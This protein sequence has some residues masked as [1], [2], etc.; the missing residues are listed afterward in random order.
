M[1]ED[2][3]QYIKGALYNINGETEPYV[4]TSISNGAKNCIM[5]KKSKLYD[6]TATNYTRDELTLSIE[7]L[8]GFATPVELTKAE[9]WLAST[10][11]IVEKGFINPGYYYII[12]C[13]DKNKILKFYFDRRTQNRTAFKTTGGATGYSNPILSPIL[14]PTL[15]IEGCIGKYINE[16]T[17]CDL[18][19]IYV[20][21]SVINSLYTADNNNQ[22]NGILPSFYE[23]K[24]ESSATNEAKPQPQQSKSFLSFFSFG[25]PTDKPTDNL[26]EDPNA[27]PKDFLCKYSDPTRKEIYF[28][29]ISTINE[30]ENAYE[31][32]ESSRQKQ[33]KL[34]EMS[35]NARSKQERTWG[36]WISENFGNNLKAEPVS[37]GPIGPTV[38][39]GPEVLEPRPEGG[40]RRTRKN[41]KA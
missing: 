19:T 30:K 5:V 21:Y 18:K 17:E 12:H 35:I 27:V 37:E 3:S 36:D 16:G 40:R 39:T 15:Q 26:Q 38:L 31:M 20:D 29:D 1:S 7:Y 8:N 24:E 10:K 22:F 25:K 33:Q 23:D 13:D 14:K 6:S 41:K 28:Q 34:K 32:S 11:Q 4:C 2:I 9:K